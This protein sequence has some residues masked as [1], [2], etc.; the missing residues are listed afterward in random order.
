MEKK[1]TILSLQR[2]KDKGEKIVALTA[3]DFPTARLL[4]EAGLDLILVG[5]S[6]GMVIQGHDSTLTV[7]LEDV[8]YHARLVR[9]AVQRTL[10]VADMPYGSY[11][12]SP[13]QAVKNGLRLVKEAQVDAVKVEGGRHRIPAITALLEAEIPVM[14][15]IGLT[16]QSVHR[17]G[18]YRIQGRTMDEIRALVDDALALQAAGCFSLVLEG[19]PHPV[20]RVLT[21]K[22]RIPTIGIGAGPACDGQILVFHDMMG[23]DPDTHFKFVRRYADLAGAITDGLTGYLGDVRQGT[24]PSLEESF[25]LETDIEEELERL[26]GSDLEDQQA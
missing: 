12:L 17:F 24:F 20:G 18:G 9:R 10:L 15:H 13:R 1:R 8:L 26:Y 5:D 4:D 3:Y 7:T 22:L 19:I 16:P 11:H 14:G 2:R 23:L 6:L 21:R 25:P